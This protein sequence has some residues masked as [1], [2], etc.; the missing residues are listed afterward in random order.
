MTTAI[1]YNDA[2]FTGLR[3]EIQ[4]LV[5]L[6]ITE[7]SVGLRVGEKYVDLTMQSQGLSEGYSSFSSPESDSL[8]SQSPCSFAEQPSATP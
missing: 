1:E 6:G 4:K 8:A 3:T 7:F 5:E 2:R